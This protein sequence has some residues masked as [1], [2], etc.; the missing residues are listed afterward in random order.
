ML[1]NNKF[2]IIEIKD[3]KN[4]DLQLNGCVMFS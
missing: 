3:G 2:K 1:N 4:K